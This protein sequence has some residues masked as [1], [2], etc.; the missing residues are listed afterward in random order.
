MARPYKSNPDL[1]YVLIQAKS[2]L[3]QAG[4]EWVRTAKVTHLLK[5]SVEELKEF[6]TEFA[7]HAGQTLVLPGRIAITEVVEDAIPENL[8]KR[9]K[10]DVTF[11][12]AIEPFLKRKGKDGGILTKGGK[13]ILRFTSYDMAGAMQDTLLDHDGEL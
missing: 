8:A 12:E 11:E 9:L 10:K 1:G 7:S 3:P 6:I 5:G 13:R 2:V 4:G